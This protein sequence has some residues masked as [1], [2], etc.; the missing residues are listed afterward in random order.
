VRT[1]SKYVRRDFRRITGMGGLSA[2]LT[3]CKDGSLARTVV[4]VG[5]PDSYSAAQ[6]VR[7]CPETSEWNH[8]R[9]MR[10]DMRSI[11]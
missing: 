8:G 10:R 5:I 2:F 3:A 7:A 11:A 9:N 1:D 6:D 4:N